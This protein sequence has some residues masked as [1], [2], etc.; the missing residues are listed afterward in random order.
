MLITK[1]KKAHLCLIISL[2]IILLSGCGGGSEAPAAPPAGEQAD[3]QAEIIPQELTISAAASITDVLE[4]LK[5]YYEEKSVHTLVM[6]YGSS[7]ALQQQIEQG[8]PADVFISAAERQ[9]N[10]L[11]EQGLIYT[12]SRV[13]LLENDVVLIVPAARADKGIQNFASLAGEAVRLLAIGNPES[14]P[15]GRYAKEALSSLGLWETLEQKLVLAKDVRQ[16]LAYV[17]TGNVDAG[18]VYKT[19]ALTSTAVKVVDTA[20]AGS[21]VPVIYPAAI[22][23]NS[24]KRLAAEDFMAFLQSDQAEEIFEKH[25]F[26]FKAGKQEQ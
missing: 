7:G 12:E 10:A 9:M 17:E 26:I 21:H 2:L 14:V 22:V 24:G 18:I 15:A 19:D 13:D 6:N 4:E 25:G 20:P 23:A 1:T 5:L 8:A 16:V 3:R 11:Q